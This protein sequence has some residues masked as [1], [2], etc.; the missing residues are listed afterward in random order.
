MPTLDQLNL[1]LG[2][3][4]NP[5]WQVHQLQ[6]YRLNNPSAMSATMKNNIILNTGDMF[7][8]QC[9]TD[10][11]TQAKVATISGF[12]LVPKGIVAIH[13]TKA[14]SVQAATLNISST[15]A[16]A[17]YYHG[18]ALTPNVIKAD[19]VVTMQYDGTR[20]NIIAIE[21]LQQSESPSDLW[22]DMGLPSGLK[23]AKKNIDLSQADKFAESE[24]QYECSFFSW[25]NT[26][27]HNPTSNTSFSP[28]SFGSANDQEPYVSSPGAALTANMSAS[29]DFARVNL[30]APWRL[31]TTNEFKELFDN[32]DYVQADGETVISSETTNKLVTVNNVTGLYIKSKINGKLLFFPCCGYGDGSSRNYR[33]SRG[34]YWSSSLRSQTYGLYLYFSSGGVSPQDNNNRFI[35]FV[36][37]AVQ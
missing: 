36:G 30:G 24:F 9:T 8:G 1:N 20:Y 28:Y 12:L 31:P 32:I 25:G 37:R 22:V 35:G 4:A 11:T 34:Y 16:K 29:Y 26:D 23:W 13:F 17:I 15:G 14:V 10:A 2:T 27:G 21:G 18:A 19:N 6:D 5:N 7:Y 3:E 33:G